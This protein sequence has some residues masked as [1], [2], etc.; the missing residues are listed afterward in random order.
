MHIE[1]FQFQI[2][3][4]EVKNKDKAKQAK[5]KKNKNQSEQKTQD[6]DKTDEEKRLEKSEVYESKY[7][8]EII[9]NFNHVLDLMEQQE[10]DMKVFL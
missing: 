1:G 6:E 8:K 10:K 5:T 2:F 7:V 9:E 3:F 4:S